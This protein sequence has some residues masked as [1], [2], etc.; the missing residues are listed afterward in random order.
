V[1]GADRTYL[2]RM[3]LC[4]YCAEEIQ[5]AAIRCKHCRSDLAGP[6]APPRRR[7]ARRLLAGAA[8]LLSLAAVPFV[9]RPILGQLGREACQ[10]ESWV[11]WHAAMRDQCL[12]PAYVCEHM[13]TRELL[14]DPD[15]ARSFRADDTAG[16]LSELVGRMRTSY[17]CAP[18]GERALRR[19]VPGEVTPSFPADQDAPRSL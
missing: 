17:G 9:A 11:E 14:Q 2:F 6:A 13:T 16:Y 10:P 7:G 12:T 4:P 8:M 15:V 18:E 3:K 5:D 1:G 19:A